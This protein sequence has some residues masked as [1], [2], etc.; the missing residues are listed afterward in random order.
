MKSRGMTLHGSTLLCALVL[1]ALVMAV[2]SGSVTPAPGFAQT[3]PAAVVRAVSVQGVVEAR[4]VGQTTWQ[5]VRL[6]DTFA[7]GDTIRVGP[8]SRADI[9][10][11]DRTHAALYEAV[12]GVE[13]AALDRVP[14]GA[15]T[16]LGKLIR[17][18]AAH[19]LYH[20]GQIQ[21]LKKLRP[22]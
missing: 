7:P 9:A 4:R 13:D 3:P 14:P 1:V 22:R 19:D 10:L 18:I 8:R 2:G 11:L 17:G 15:K 16:V 6:N 21:L 20:A 12:A 5:A